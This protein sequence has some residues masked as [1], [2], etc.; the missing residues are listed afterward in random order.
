MKKGKELPEISS[1]RRDTLTMTKAVLKLQNLGALI[2]G[3]YQKQ[4]E[5]SLKVLRY[6]KWHFTLPMVSSVS[7]VFTHDAHFLMPY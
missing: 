5:A 4:T 2:V 1:L 7:L 6:M 3:K